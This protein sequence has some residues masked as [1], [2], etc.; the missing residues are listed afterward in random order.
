MRVVRRGSTYIAPD[1]AVFDGNVKIDGNFIL[2]RNSHVWGRLVVGGKL[3]IGPLSTVG[4]DVCAQKAIIGH[5]VQI[6]G[7]LS[8]VEDITVCD[9][10]R[11][12][13][14]EAGGNVILRPGVV[15]G[16][17]RSEAVIYVFGRIH[18]GTLT[19]RNV[20]VIAA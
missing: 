18:S 13:R 1:G 11:I 4:R 14:I 6:K 5:A 9:R 7:L 15:V 16:D 2:P 19:G 17:V 12:G 3:E 8:T 10:A 20:K